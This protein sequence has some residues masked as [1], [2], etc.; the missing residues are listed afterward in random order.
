MRRRIDAPPRPDR[1]IGR[2]A[3]RP[4]TVGARV[5]ADWR[6]MG[7]PLAILRAF[8]GSTFVFAG[9]QKL[10]DPNCRVGGAPATSAPS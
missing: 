7:W 6:A 5:V 4:A 9:M 2:G 8:L 10:L 1:S 3:H